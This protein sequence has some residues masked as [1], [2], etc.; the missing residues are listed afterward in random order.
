MTNGIVS[1]DV[2]FA[3]PAKRKIC[4]RSDPCFYRQSLTKG[5]GIFAETMLKEGKIKTVLSKNVEKRENIGLPIFVAEDIISFCKGNEK[6]LMEG[7]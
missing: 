1:G 2:R 6:N 7:K 4:R 3:N 5:Y